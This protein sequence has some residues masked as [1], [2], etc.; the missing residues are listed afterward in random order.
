MTDH[1]LAVD[2]GGTNMRAAVVDADGEVQLRRSQPTPRQDTCPDA[3]IGLVGGVLTD[4]PVTTAVIGVPGRI[5]H[6]RGALEYAPNL[7]SHWPEALREDLLSTHLDVPVSV[8]NDADLATVGEA[9]FGAG[10]GA[11]DVV[12]VTVST[13]VGAGVVLAGRLV[14]GRRSLAELGHTII[15]LHALAHGHPATVEDRGSGTA[16]GRLGTA[17]GLPG[18]GAALSALVRD[19]DPAATEVWEQV[20]EVVGVAIANV[21]HLFAPEV[22]VLGGGMGRDPGLLTTVRGGLKDHGPRAL[23]PPIE[24]RTAELGDDA[25]LVGA[26]GW[27][28]ATEPPSVGEDTSE[29]A[30]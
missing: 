13:G 6:A 23:Q 11:A 28:R 14:R 24:V 5:D 29:V 26:A 16:L 22:V 4:H 17:R 8:A 25:G 3:L 30:Q 15:D 12:Y 19:G 18:S 10:R 21:A 9:F 20:A 2:L 7:P 27:A 1:V